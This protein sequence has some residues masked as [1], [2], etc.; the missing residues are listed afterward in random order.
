MDGSLCK[1]M[2]RHTR[3][4]AYY[5]ELNNTAKQGERYIGSETK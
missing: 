3:Q 5:D 4:Q 2:P 1:Y